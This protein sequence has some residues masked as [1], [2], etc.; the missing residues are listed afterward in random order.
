[1]VLE[2]LASARF[3]TLTARLASLSVRWRDVFAR[4]LGCLFTALP[5]QQAA[6]VWD[7]LL[8]QG[9][10][11]L[12]RCAL[13]LL[14]LRRDEMVRITQSHET[15]GRAARLEV[16]RLLDLRG[17]GAVDAAWTARARSFGPS[18][19]RSGGTGHG[20][21][22][23]A[24]AARALAAAHEDP[25]ARLDRGEHLRAR[26]DVWTA[27]ATAVELAL[28]AVADKLSA[29]E[30]AFS[31]CAKLVK[32]LAGLPG[33]AP[34]PAR[35]ASPDAASPDAASPDDASP[36]DA[37]TTSHAD[38]VGLAAHCDALLVP[39]RGAGRP[40]SS[41]D[42]AIACPELHEALSHTY[43]EA[44]RLARAVR[45]QR[46]QLD[47]RLALARQ[48]QAA[49]EALLD[50]SAG[51]RAD[52]K[53]GRGEAG[54]RRRD[55]KS[56]QT[57]ADF[58]QR[59]AEVGTFG[60]IAGSAARSPEGGERARSPQ[61][62]QHLGQR[63][64][65]GS[66]GWVDP[67]RARA[68]TGTRRGNP[69]NSPSASGGGNSK[70]AGGGG[71]ESGGDPSAGT[72][73][74]KRSAAA[75]G[76]SKFGA[77]FDADSMMGV[78]A[79]G[80]CTGL[81]FGSAQSPGGR[82]GQTRERPPGAADARPLLEALQSAAWAAAAAGW[83]GRA[84]LARAHCALGCWAANARGVS[85]ALAPA[86]G[87][88]G[89]RAGVSAGGASPAEGGSKGRRETGAKTRGGTLTQA[90]RTRAARSR[91][92]AGAAGPGRR[93]GGAGAGGGAGGSGRSHAGDLTLR[94]PGGDD[95][96][97]S[98]T[99]GPPCVFSHA[100]ALAPGAG[101][102][103]GERERCMETTRV[104]E[105]ALEELVLQIQRLVACFE[106]RGA[107]GVARQGAGGSGSSRIPGAADRLQERVEA[108]D[109]ST[110][111]EALQR[112]KRDRVE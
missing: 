107:V 5:A 70:F 35:N 41:R 24:L 71:G 105:E 57:S 21:P 28:G 60:R 58:V 99:F 63:S 65:R 32:R 76:N 26:A 64:P 1:M 95:E 29:A 86:G 4:W 89:A 91:D 85:V 38:S 67:S 55:D 112:L 36:D 90:G 19:S 43:E 9:R 87:R 31:V 54:R 14:C 22:E 49:C 110:L 23:G 96:A 61:E 16:E 51:A 53:R 8:L 78:T 82:S 33:P 69:E 68:E 52:G 84:A 92:P 37:P 2:G 72:R 62:T 45:V 48:R 108:A 25:R 106:V 102:A 17:M 88:D 27:A 109:L 98:R 39:P 79:D 42:G 66:R 100:D 101:A 13:A 56:G 93:G 111:I 50:A 77:R 94:P 44:L 75:A 47:V 83:S 104:S 97:F 10:A 11:A 80:L 18:G 40:R 7:C 103:R 73:A 3:P 30:Q 6:V 12:A 46:A 34:G 81:F 59:G 74:F 20:A 15:D